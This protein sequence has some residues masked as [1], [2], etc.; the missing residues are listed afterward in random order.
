MSADMLRVVLANIYDCAQMGFP[1][2]AIFIKEHEGLTWWGKVR[3]ELG[4][5]IFKTRFTGTTHLE[6]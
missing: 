2:W 6:E 5:M 1:Q 4:P 3:V